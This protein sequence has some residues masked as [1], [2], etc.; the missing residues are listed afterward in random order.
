MYHRLFKPA[1]DQNEKP[2]LEFSFSSAPRRLSSRTKNLKGRIHKRHC[3]TKADL[4]TNPPLGAE[5]IKNVPSLELAFTDPKYAYPRPETFPSHVETPYFKF[6]VVYESKISKAR[7]GRIH[8]PHGIIDTPGFVPVATNAALKYLDIADNPLNTQLIF[9]NTYHLLIHP[10]TAVV[11]E[12]G[13]I[14]RF[15]GYQRP[16]ITDSGGFQVFSMANTTSQD[17]LKGKVVRSQRS[18]PGRPPPKLLKRVDEQGAQFRSYRDGTL[19]S[20]TPESSVRA[21]KDIGA[22]III[23]LDILL[24]NAVTPRKLL[25]AF[26]RTH[27]W[28]AASLREHLKDLKQQAMY[29]VIHGGTN[30][31]L[32][33]LSLQYLSQLPF[34]GIAIGGSLG[35][36]IPEMHALI[37]AF[38]PTIP[39]KFPIHLLGIG[40]P[41][42]V[43]FGAKWGIDTF[44]SA[45]PTKTGRHGHFFMLDHDGQ[46]RT[47]D[48]TKPKFMSKTNK[49]PVEGCSCPTYVVF[50][51]HMRLS[52]SICHLVFYVGFLLS[53]TISAIPFL[54]L[55]IVKIGFICFCMNCPQMHQTFCGVCTSSVFHE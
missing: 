29:A 3:A 7:V 5:I 8:T 28:E 55:L 49:P 14:H 15:C 45:Y 20:L 50:D 4:P 54:P 10:G 24:P 9:A 18:N 25:E 19:I 40:D 38:V 46:Y 52:A 23:P 6:E 35:K 17:E 39:R 42:S 36:D 44:D 53:T 11:K 48:L 51:F 33:N 21:Q 26:H 31:R 27:R 34:Q 22:D 1:N 12:S 32:R 13:G 41:P 30:L 37:E 2:T 43:Q 47:A 16:M